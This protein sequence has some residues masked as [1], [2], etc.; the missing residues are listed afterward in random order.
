MQLTANDLLADSFVER[1]SKQD[2]TDVLSTLQRSI[3]PGGNLLSQPITLAQ[4][5][6]GL[7]CSS[8]R[9]KE[10]GHAVRAAQVFNRVTAEFPTAAQMVLPSHLAEDDQEALEAWVQ[11]FPLARGTTFLTG[12]GGRRPVREMSGGLRAIEVRWQPPLPSSS[13]HDLYKSSHDRSLWML[14]EIEDGCGGFHA[15]VAW[16]VAL[17]GLSQLARYDPARWAQMI[18]IGESRHA[19]AIETMLREGIERAPQ[20]VA[21]LLA[22]TA[23]ATSE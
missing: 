2:C 22:G 3:E 23:V 11:R 14:P 8:S 15:L 19:V 13:D 10:R 4:A 1:H 9:L 12:D 21:D 16:L 20:M 18:N 5:W 17:F 6:A 7:V